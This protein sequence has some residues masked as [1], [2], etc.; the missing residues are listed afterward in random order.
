MELDEEYKQFELHLKETQ[1]R[2]QNIYSIKCS[3]AK[4]EIRK[5]IEDNFDKLM[6]ALTHRRDQLLLSVDH[7]FQQ[8]G[9]IL[10]S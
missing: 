4:R 5:Q 1:K 10:H 8:N 6:K 2:L 9:M 7:L 3:E